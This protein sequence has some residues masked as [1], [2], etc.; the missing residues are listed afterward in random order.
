MLPAHHYRK[1]N[2]FMRDHH[3]AQHHA[4]SCTSTI[5]HRHRHAAISTHPSHDHR[6]AAVRAL[7]PPPC[8]RTIVLF[9]TLCGLGDYLIT[10]HCLPACHLAFVC[11]LVCA[12]TALATAS[13]PPMTA[14]ARAFRR[15]KGTGATL[16]P[17]GGRGTTDGSTPRGAGRQW[18]GGLASPSPCP[19]APCLSVHSEGDHGCSSALLTGKAMDLSAA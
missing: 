3:R 9:G 11:S 15:R 18:Q 12:C 19:L 10:G 16:R 6:K 17:Q 4:S 5:P 2:R 8:R 13:F 7:A 1:D 14:A